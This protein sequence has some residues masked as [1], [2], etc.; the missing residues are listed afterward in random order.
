MKEGGEGGGGGQIGP[1][2]EKLQSKSP[3]LLDLPWVA[4]NFERSYNLVPWAVLDLWIL[5]YYRLTMNN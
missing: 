1:P 2:Q 4:Q 3:A 5:G